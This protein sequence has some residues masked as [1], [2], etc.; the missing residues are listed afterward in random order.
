MRRGI[1]AVAYA[2]DSE[3]VPALAREFPFLTAFCGVIDITGH[4]RPISYH[5]EIVFGLRSDPLIAM[6]RPEH[7]GHRIAKQS[8]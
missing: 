4:R 5:R 2:E 7:H 3:A 1:G 6:R 8:P